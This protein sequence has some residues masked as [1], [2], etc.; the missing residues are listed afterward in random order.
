MEHRKNRKQT[1]KNLREGK[2][3]KIHKDLGLPNFGE[4]KRK[5][6]RRVGIGCYVLMYQNRMMKEKLRDAMEEE[7]V[8]IGRN[9][10]TAPMSV[11][12]SGNRIVGS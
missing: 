9:M 5:L 1:Q 10:N 7:G 3:R 11:S 4:E 6:E 8:E 12:F 2:I